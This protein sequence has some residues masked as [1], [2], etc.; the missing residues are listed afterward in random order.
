MRIDIC[1]ISD[2]NF[3]QHLAVTM[4]SILSNADKDDEL[5]FYILLDKTLSMNLRE[6]II[7]LKKIKDC[8]I[9]F[10]EVEKSL[11]N[12][13]SKVRKMANFKFFLGNIL[14]DLDKVLYL[15]CDLIV[16]KSL[17]ELFNE[18]I[19]NYY[20]AG[21]DNIGHYFLFKYNDYWISDFYI[22]SGVMLINLDSWRKNNLAEQF[23]KIKEE[24][25][26]NFIFVDQDVIN[27]CCDG[28][29]KPLDLSW[30]MHTGFFKNFYFHPKKQEIKKAI[31]NP[32]IIH[33]SSFKKPWNG[34]SPLMKYYYKYLKLTSFNKKITFSFRLKVFYDYVLYLLDIFDRRTKIFCLPIIKKIR[35]NKFS[36]KIKDK[37]NIICGINKKDLKK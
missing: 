5:L 24:N 22:N 25:I 34:Y 19:K 13:Y 26:K 27:I 30:N 23:I 4:A 37:I 18:D 3:I 36:R 31:A 7:E 35:K 28:K 32:Q 15:D 6:K 21:A 29:I 9:F 20:L 11:F 14:K 1:L 33:F 12:K 17:K 2:E 16:L 10:I 8:T